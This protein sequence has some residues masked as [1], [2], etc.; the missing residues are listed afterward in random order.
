[1]PSHPHEAIAGLEMMMFCP[2]L[3]IMFFRIISNAKAG[4]PPAASY[5]RDE[6][7]VVI[8]LLALPIV[9][10]VG[11]QLTHGQYFARYFLACVL[12]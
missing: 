10:A 12:G 2:S 9:G 11:V 7:V 4:S 8:G 6:W 1:M 3:L 5:K